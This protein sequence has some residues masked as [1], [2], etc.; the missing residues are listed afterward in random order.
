MP[1]PEHSC[2]GLS[3]IFVD[4][5]YKEHHSP[6]KMVAAING[7]HTIGSAKI[8]NSGYDGFWSDSK[9]QGVFN[10][11]YY[12]SLV[13]KGWGPETAVAGN[14]KKN[15]WQHIDHN[16]ENAG[17]KQMMLNSDLC[18][19]YNNNKEQVECVATTKPVLELILSFLG[20]G[21]CTKYDD[22]GLD[23]HASNGM[24]CAWT[25]IVTATFL[26]ISDGNDY[27]G[28]G[29][30]V[31]T[32]DGRG[33]CCSSEDASSY[34]DCSA[35]VHQGLNDKRGP[36]EYDIYEF[37]KS[38]KVFLEAYSEAWVMATENGYTTLKPII[39]TGSALIIMSDFA[40]FFKLNLSTLVVLM[41]FY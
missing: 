32:G 6:W 39:T 41:A 12:K 21:S 7:A 23:L 18:M 29:Q 36:A 15:Q 13:L 8:A 26:D 38:E 35:F 40:H 33:E 14:T 9:N 3:N 11:D 30:N 10:N 16:R 34:G 28:G 17:H 19:L 37:I 27:C 25:P 22:N 31:Q 1:N 20:L 5:I 4:H 2:T 24:C